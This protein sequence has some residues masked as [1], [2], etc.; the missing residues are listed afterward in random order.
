MSN[1]GRWTLVYIR[2]ERR[3]PKRY[4]TES[5]RLTRERRNIDKFKKRHKF[6]SVNN[7]ITVNGEKYKVDLNLDKN[8][9]T[10]S[11]VG[12]NKQPEIQFNRKIFK[13]KPKQTDAVLQHEI[14]HSKMNMIQIH[15]LVNAIIK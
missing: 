8:K 14:G 5:K 7:T 2:S 9:D 6:D 10:Q 3:I 12:K 11:V 15:R 4:V 13:L 1:G